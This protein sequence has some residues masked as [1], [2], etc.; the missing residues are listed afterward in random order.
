MHHK[1]S[2]IC[3]HCVF[4]ELKAK[5][6]ALSAQVQRLEGLSAQMEQ[7]QATLEAAVPEQADSVE[8]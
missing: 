2:L 4:Q 1:P 7:L 3:N 6:D 8:M 5:L